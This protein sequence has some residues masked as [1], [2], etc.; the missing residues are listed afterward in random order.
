MGELA[1]DQADELIWV[2]DERFDLINQLNKEL[3]K[4]WTFSDVLLE[5]HLW[6]RRQGAQSVGRGRSVE[7]EV[8]NVASSL[9]LPYVMRTRFEGRG[10]ETAPCD[11][12]IPAGGPDAMIAVAIK[13]FNST[14]SKLTDAVGEIE[15]MATVRR[16]SQYVFVVVDGI[17]WLSRQAD[18]KRIYNLWQSNQIDG[19]YT[20]S[21]LDVFKREL[22][23]AATRLGFLNGSV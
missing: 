21:H 12:A 4:E 1:R 22:S 10:G 3:L 15:R 13:G 23:T 14:G 6:S 19:L 16:P 7:D 11:L 2:L 5:R 17:G 18:L 9:Q 8:E 20:L